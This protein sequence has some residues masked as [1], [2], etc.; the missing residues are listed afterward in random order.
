MRAPPGPA[1]HEDRGFHGEADE[2][3]P[4]ASRVEPGDALPGRS[5]VEAGQQRQRCGATAGSCPML[6]PT[7]D[8]RGTW[9][10]FTQDRPARGI[11]KAS[12]SVNRSSA[13]NS[14]AI[15]P[16]SDLHECRARLQHCRRVIG[17]R[18]SFERASRGG[19]CEPDPERV[20][21]GRRA[22]G[23]TGLAML[24]QMYRPTSWKAGSESS[25]DSW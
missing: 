6:A 12:G 7:S 5:R 15:C 1:A 24:R 23:S 20:V 4:E 11:G 25:T 2:D 18:C 22:A 8:L 14:S 10:P 17:C 16:S 3:P 21:R 19:Y 13:P 9:W